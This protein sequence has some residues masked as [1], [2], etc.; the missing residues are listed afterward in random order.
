MALGRYEEARMGRTA[1]VQRD[2]RRNA[3][4]YHAA[5]PVAMA[6]DLIL[7]AASGEGLLARY[8]WLY[9]WRP[10]QPLPSAAR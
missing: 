9:G 5:W 6:R 7:S 8:D 1:R 4:A 3:H 10:S 2:A